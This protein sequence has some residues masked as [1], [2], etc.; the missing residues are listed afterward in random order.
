[1]SIIQPLNIQETVD[2]VSNLRPGIHIFTTK[3][4]TEKTMDFRINNLWDLMFHGSIETA[5]KNKFDG[6]EIR[7]TAAYFK[8]GIHNEPITYEYSSS[9]RLG[10]VASSD[11][12]YSVDTNVGFPL[13]YVN[14]DKFTPETTS[15]QLVE[16]T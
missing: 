11:K 5:S 7:A 14:L 13:F 1:L 3:E 8:D 16:N 2:G 10:M 4:G 9:R 12:L 6:D 15:E